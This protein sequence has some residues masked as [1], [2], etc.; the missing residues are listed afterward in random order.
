MSTINISLPAPQV[1]FVDQLVIQHGFANRSELVRSLLR[2]VSHQP[3][4]LDTAATYPF[5]APASTS[6][7]KIS[8]AF[9]EVGVHSKEFVKDLEEGLAQSNYFTK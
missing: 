5:V 6:K 7:T 8:A 2:L 1:S 3:G 9:Q 4:I